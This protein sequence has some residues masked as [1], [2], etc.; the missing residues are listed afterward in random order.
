MLNRLFHQTAIPI[1]YQS[2][3]MHLYLDIAWFGVL[4]GS[5]INF[6]NVYATRIGA[7]AF[8]IGLIGAMSA[9]V[10]L[11]LAIPAGFWLQKRNIEH[12]IFWTSV[13]YRIGFLGFVLLPWLFNADG[14]IVFIIAITFLMAIPLT[15]L[16][17]GFNALFAEA[18]PNEYRAHV[19]G[20]RN[21]MFAV[22]FMLASLLSGFILNRITFPIGYQIVFAIG[23]IGAAMSS[24]H[25]YF[26]RPLVDEKAPPLT[27][28]Q[29]E[30][31][32]QAAS[33]R[34]VFSIL[35]LD[36]LRT[37]FLT[38]LLCLFGFH[39]AQNLATPIYPLFNVRVLNLND[40][41]IGIGTALF[42]VTMFIGS[43]RLRRIV[44][45]LG[46]KRT[47]GWGV[48]GQAIYPILLA[49]SSQ[50]WQYY[51]VSII[52]GFFWALVAGSYANYM[53]EHIPPDDR[54]T[55]LA[56]YNII[57]NI[58]M[59]VSSL[60]GPAIAD[61]IG[62]FYALILIGIFRFLAGVYILKWG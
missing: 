1:E 20:L 9:V 2:N 62:L 26:L 57:L 4:S 3:F 52:G 58:A 27:Q 23:F 51:S 49:F 17:V 7:T 22:T 34:G 50:V 25:L 37:P 31:P 21:V 55:H 12:A 32:S 45:S 59:L 29:P 10:N 42:Y 28:P 41:Q 24:Y 56:W 14:Q 33:P 6:L 43:M 44:H 19:A 47:T 5:T 46:N 53:L 18:V 13:F 30:P 16:G 15:P 38:V 60:A 35:R 61:L 40:N 54:P 8:Q 48:A 39:L 11:F 36:I